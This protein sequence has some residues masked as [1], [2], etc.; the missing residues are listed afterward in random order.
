MDLSIRDWMLVIGVLLV[1]ALALDGYRRA[2]RRHKNQ[3]RLSRNAKRMARKGIEAEAYPSE[4]SGSGP[5]VVARKEETGPDFAD[6][7]RENFEES[8]VSEKTEPTLAEPDGDPLDSCRFS[9]IDSDDVNENSG[10]TDN[11]DSYPVDPLFADPFKVGKKKKFSSR[12]KDNR[13][14]QPSLFESEQESRKR[15]EPQKIIRLNVIASGEEGY[16]G[17]DLLHILL[18]CDCRFGEMN[19]FHRYESENAQ[20]NIQFSIVNMVEPGIFN[21]DDIK[22]FTTPGVSFFMMLP[23]PGNPIEAFDCMV[24]TAQCLVRNLGG[25]LNDEA[26]S[27]VTEQ[28]LEHCRQGIRDFLKNQLVGV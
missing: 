4:L 12:E 18:A 14:I 9:A 20:G 25:M 2:Q 26:Q 11:I 1:L 21:L 15:A 5:R 22:N 3:V 24:E 6:D 16:A 28:T 10:Y 8:C 27:T 17:E 7:F 23:G 13:H 19:I